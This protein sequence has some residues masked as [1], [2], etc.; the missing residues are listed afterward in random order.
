[1]GGGVTRGSHGSH[2]KT[3]ESAKAQGLSP[4]EQKYNKVSTDSQ[5]KQSHAKGS[6]KKGTT[7]VKVNGPKQLLWAG[8]LHYEMLSKEEVESCGQYGGKLKDNS[9]F[10]L[11]LSWAGFCLQSLWNR[12]KLVRLSTDSFTH[13]ANHKNST[14]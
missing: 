3:A 7:K 9:T 2:M 13:T 10:Y 1:M 14:I 4:D 8:I 12:K 11:I 6:D 5:N